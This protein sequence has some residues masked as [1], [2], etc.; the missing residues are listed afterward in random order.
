MPSIE[1]G[2]VGS[3]SASGGDLG[4][5]DTDDFVDICVHRNYLETAALAISAHHEMLWNM[6]TAMI[7]MSK[8]GDEPS[9]QSEDED[10]DLVQA[11][12]VAL[13][14]GRPSDEN[15]KYSFNELLRAY[16]LGSS[17]SGGEPRAK[18]Y[19]LG[20]GS[21]GDQLLEESVIVNP[22]NKDEKVVSAH[23]ELLVIGKRGAMQRA[24]RRRNA[25]RPRRC[26][27][28]KSN[29]RETRTA[30]T[31]EHT[32]YRGSQSTKDDVIQYPTD[33]RSMRRRWKRATTFH[34]N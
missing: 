14:L 13:V 26:P 30:F 5:T 27:S 34:N 33:Q 3:R 25:I 22:A 19:S 12:P 29:R 21:C 16:N 9:A 28:R 7:D 8:Q 10:D 1:I 18:T 2:V 17:S 6:M 4:S 11:L 15:A 24:R 23:D 32:V 20:G 31:H